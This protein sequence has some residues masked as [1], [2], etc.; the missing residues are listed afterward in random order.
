MHADPPFIDAEAVADEIVTIETC[1]AVVP[2][3]CP[4]LTRERTRNPLDRWPTWNVTARLYRFHD[5]VLDR[6]HMVLLHRGRII[7]QTCYLQSEAALAA[8]AVRTDELVRLPK[9]P[10]Y[11]PCFD[12]WDANYYHWTAHSI[13]ALHVIRQRY[14]DGG[15]CLLL[16]PLRPSQA[17]SIRLVGADRFDAV[18]TE[19]G[20]QYALPQAAYLDI[21]AGSLDFSVSALSAA[22]YARVSASVADRTAP[23]AKLYID[24]SGSQSRS[25]PN[26][27]ALAALM[28]ARGFSVVRPETMT[29]SA[30]VALFRAAS[31][32]VGLHGAGLA[33]IAYC[34]PGTLVY[35]IMPAHNLNPCYM[36]LA[37]QGGLRYWTD[38]FETGA[39]PGHTQPWARDLDLQAISSRL[40]DL[41]SW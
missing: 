38:M 34:R 14:A 23:A 39:P 3:L 29:L 4:E 9:G 6:T 33:N 41:A 31:M 1:Q 12:H 2:D 24:R 36:V 27:A 16:P 15:I 35:E 20:R 26:E 19:A 8:L 11:I 25:V 5:V 13:P 37:L 10:V 22:A 30:Q 21:V 32:V 28:Q 18:T 40:T 7:A 17:D